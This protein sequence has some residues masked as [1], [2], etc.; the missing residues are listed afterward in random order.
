MTKSVAMLTHG[1]IFYILIRIHWFT[2]LSDSYEN[3]PELNSNAL[4]NTQDNKERSRALAG[5]YVTH[6]NMNYRLWTQE[7]EGVTFILK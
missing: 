2:F 7:V 1:F 6:G 5:R 4:L 3:Q